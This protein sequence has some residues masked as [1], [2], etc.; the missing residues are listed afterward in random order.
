MARLI[1]H[2]WYRCQAITSVVEANPSHPRAE[3]LLREALAAA[4]SQNEPNRVASVARWPLRL[5]V[6]RGSINAADWTRELLQVIATE[7]HGLRRLDGLSAILFAVA[8]SEELRALV[9]EPFMLAAS[10]SHGWRTERIIDF[11][12]TILIPIDKKAAAKLLDA[13]PPSRH[14][15]RSRTSL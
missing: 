9:L 10:A 14:T 6:D 7:R 4:A 2:P 15:K 11:I 13:R 8:P 1:E 5:L 3:D 12:A